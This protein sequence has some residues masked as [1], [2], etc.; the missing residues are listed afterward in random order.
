MYRMIYILIQIPLMYPIKKQ[1]M[2]RSHV[3]LPINTTCM[4]K[5]DLHYNKIII[6]FA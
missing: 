6:I 2:I 5:I 1:T 3:F 4:S